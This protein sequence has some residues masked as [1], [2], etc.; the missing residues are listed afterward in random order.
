MTGGPAAA[1]ASVGGMSIPPEVQRI[2]QEGMQSILEKSGSEG[3]AQF[4]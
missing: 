4:E 2:L 1:T 3:A